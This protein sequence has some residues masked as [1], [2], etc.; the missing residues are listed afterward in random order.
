MAV[1]IGSCGRLVLVLSAWA[2]LAPGTAQAQLE[3]LRRIFGGAERVKEMPAAGPATTSSPASRNFPGGL[4]LAEDREKTRG[5]SMVSSQLELKRYAE[6]ARRLGELLEDPA[7]AD[8]FL[9]ADTGGGSR[10]SFKAELRRL[11]GTL[12]PEARQAYELTFG[13]RARQM[14]DEAGRKGDLETLH[15]VARRYPHTEAGYEAVYLLSGLLLDQGQAGEALLWLSQLRESS[16][17][18]ARYEPMLSLLTATAALKADQQDLARE[19]L[20]ALKKKSPKAVLDIGG[21]SRPIF[22]DDAQALAW[23]AE[24]TGLSVKPVT[25]EVIAQSAPLMKSRTA[26]F[27]ISSRLEEVAQGRD[28]VRGRGETPLPTLHPAVVG[29]TI[30]TRTGGGIIAVSLKTGKEVWRYPSERDSDGTS[31]EQMIWRDVAFGRIATDGQTAFLVEYSYPVPGDPNQY[32]GNQ[33][34]F[35]GGGMKF[36][37]PMFFPG[38][39]FGGMAMA[40]DESSASPGAPSGGNLLSAIDVSTQGKLLWRV[41]GPW[42]VNPQ[43]AGAFFL[44]A[45]T[46]VND[47][48]YVMAEIQN[49]IHLVVLEKASGRLIWVQRLGDIENSIYQDPY[50]RMAG[51]SPVVVSGVVVCPTSCGGIVAV[52]IARRQ[53]LWAYQHPRKDT[54][55]TQPSHGRVA[56]LNQGSRWADNTLWVVD[57]RVIATPLESEDMHC[58]DLKTGKVLWTKNRGAS[59]Y[60]ACVHNGVV[61]TVDGR[62]VGS[63]KLTSGDMAW[64]SSVQLPGKSR[65]SGRGVRSGDF[66]YLPLTDSE[67]GYDKAGQIARIDLKAGKIVDVATSQRQFV[68]GNLVFHDGAFISQG[69]EYLEV[70]DQVAALD[71]DLRKRLVSNARDAEAWARLA[72]LERGTGKL[73][74]AIGHLRK[75]YDLSPSDTIRSAY[76]AILLDGIEAKLSNRAELSEQL[77]RLAK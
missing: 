56:Q 31:T 58:L 9:N 69:A 49:A 35:F 71:S 11:V 4:Q 7:T 20:L 65:P 60:V 53:L 45:P 17:K 52:D 66:Y 23:L 55:M 41:G 2:V 51:A 5:L 24:I 25:R 67:G 19:T 1:R 43:L 6:V 42:M 10:R 70:F 21:Q 59:L 28:S 76:A 27:T 38:G 48:L 37:G 72:D 63:K 33:R 61:V 15:S 13:P 73:A 29:D 74:E 16:D 77:V 3:G 44:G 46:P 22:S 68:P 75:A 62:Y 34:V 14:L 8:F 47:R 30:L 26:E 64:S 39:G 12:P 36:G 57:G 50:R 32:N 40:A 18:G 54:S